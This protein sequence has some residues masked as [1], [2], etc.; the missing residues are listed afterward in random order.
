VV[1]DPPARLLDLLGYR[2]DAREPLNIRRLVDPIHLATLL[3]ELR[4]ASEGSPPARHHPLLLVT[5]GGGRIWASV[6]LRPGRGKGELVTEV[7][8]RVDRAVPGERTPDSTRLLDAMTRS[9]VQ[10]IE[11]DDP[12]LVFGGLLAD[13]LDLTDSVFGFI[14]EVLTDDRGDP[15]IRAHAQTNIAWDDATRDLYDR[16]LAEGMEFHDLATLFGACLTTRAPVIANDPASDPRSGGLPDGH[17]PLTSFLGLPLVYGEALIGVVGIAN[18]AGGY[19]EAT[20]DYLTPLLATAAGIT[21]AYRMRAAR[22]LVERQLTERDRILQ[23]IVDHAPEIIYIKDLEGRYVITNPAA[24]LLRGLEPS[25]F[26][27]R[28]DFDLIP[29]EE[30][31]AIRRE[32]LRVIEDGVTRTSET[33]FVVDGRRRT[34]A[35]TKSPWRDA[36]GAVVGI[37]GLATEVT[38]RTE[39]AEAL[40]AERELHARN[41]SLLQGIIVSAGEAIVTSDIEGRILSFNPAAEAMFGREESAT[42]GQSVEI[43][44]P[45]DQVAQHREGMRRRSQG[46]RGPAAGR[47]TRRTGMRADGAEVPVEI[48]LAEV[49]REEDRRIV[50]L[51]RD[52][53]EHVKIQEM[54]DDFVSIVSHELRTP[55]T[56]IQGA[57]GLMLGGAVG[58]LTPEARELVGVAHHNAQRL[59]RLT[60]DLLD[61]QKL[62]AGRMTY[63]FVVTDLTAIARQT[64]AAMEPLA[65]SRGI[66]LDLVAPETALYASVDPDRIA[67]VLT[68]LMG[69][70]VAV[71]DHGSPVTV[72]LREDEDA[73]VVDV[74][75]RGPGIAESDRE[76]VW[77]KFL[78]VESGAAAKTHG[79][80]IGMPLARA[81]VEA[82]GGT[83]DF[84]SVVGEGT[85]FSVRIPRR[86]G[87]S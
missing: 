81:L 41:E 43:L 49:S 30:A 58:E 38:D 57:L 73:A 66:P 35:N 68:N 53:T 87:M 13:F 44:V 11:R 63:R 16:T 31:E 55:L 56:S 7:L 75:D 61:L 39:A 33:A 59:V 29:P 71:S 74:V 5:R 79:T 80:G 47:W 77:G 82:H 26:I 64:I 23:A 27:G 1:V 52:L 45:R 51:I 78:R 10:F 65:T 86:V 20:V 60:N 25:A 6:E 12:A 8:V 50:A 19:D 54:K 14:G 34:Y 36:D 2:A 24:A 72:R 67:Q 40:R 18:R 9:Q 83:L 4:A 62:E 21:D 85:T 70:A 28:T 15:Y 17:P 3:E 37:I 46:I 42:I 48:F 32:D 69:N 84:S 76:R 22:R